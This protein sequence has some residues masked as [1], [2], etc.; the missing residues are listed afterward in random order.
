M[1][2]SPNTLPADGSAAAFF[3]I[4]NTVIKGASLFAMA[5]GLL[6][7]DVLRRSDMV[8]F[9]VKQAKFVFAGTENM[10]DIAKIQE[11]ALQIIKDQ[12]VADMRAIA[13][14]VFD[15]YLVDKLWPGTIAL[16][17]FHMRAGHQV[18]L[19][20]A[21]PIEIAEVI[22]KRLELTGAV[23]TRAEVIDGVYTGRLEGDPVHGPA[24]A[25]AVLDLSARE[26]FSL[27]KCSAYSDSA[28][29]IPMLSLVGNP[30][31]INPDHQLRTHAEAA[32]WQ[33]R[34]FRSTRYAMRVGMPSA[35]LA[36]LAVGA[37]VGSLITA[38]AMRPKG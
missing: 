35:A 3:D 8:G 32:G 22:A 10:E 15:Q 5:R 24:K 16:A 1:T 33:V 9:A 17:R 26:G 28:N 31:A 13:D 38:R 4:D 27:E 25:Q 36:G 30:C 37:V 23:G 20:S 29:D 12:K 2:N 14:Q 11:S 18:W 34:D 21:T 19:V 7:E 6:K